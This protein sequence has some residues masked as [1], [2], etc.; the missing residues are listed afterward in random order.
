M[1]AICC[2]SIESRVF[3]SKFVLFPRLFCSFSFF[4]RFS[5]GRSKSFCSGPALTD[6]CCPQASC[7]C[8][9]I[10]CLRSVQS[11]R[12]FQFFWFVWFVWCLVFVFGVWCSV[13]GVWCLVLLRLTYL[14]CSYSRLLSRYHCLACCGVMLLSISAVS[15][16]WANTFSASSSLRPAVYL[17][18]VHRTPGGGGVVKGSQG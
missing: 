15:S 16:V 2:R 8:G 13:F 10:A 6:G 3:G 7:C 14:T 4:L 9:S 12:V 1:R 5:S 17:Y 18:T 11:F